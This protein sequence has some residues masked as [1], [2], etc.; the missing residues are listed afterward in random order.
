MLD[1]GSTRQWAD[2]VT[3]LLALF[4]GKL[5]QHQSSQVR[6]W[7]PPAARSKAVSAFDRNDLPM[8]WDFAEPSFMCNSVGGWLRLVEQ[9][10]KGLSKVAHGTGT[11]RSV[12]ART[13]H[14]GDSLIAT[15]PPYFD[16]IGYAD[17]SDYFYVWHRRALKSGA[18]GF[19]RD[20]R[21][22]KDERTHCYSIAPWGEQRGRA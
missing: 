10:L 20:S 2:A 1:E 18:P 13:A 16:A 4:L 22:T 15:D 21:R 11:V 9:A 7:F 8:L 6:W 5:A 14:C 17:L 12:D 3:T 19:V